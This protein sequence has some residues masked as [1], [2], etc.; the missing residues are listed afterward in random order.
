MDGWPLRNEG[1]REGEGERGK[2]KVKMDEK[3]VPIDVVVWTTDERVRVYMP[4]CTRPYACAHLA[5]RFHP[6]FSSRLL[7]RS[8][9]SFLCCPEYVRVPTSMI[10]HIVLYIQHKLAIILGG[11]G[12]G[13]SRQNGR[14]DR[15]TDGRAIYVISLLIFRLLSVSMMNEQ[16]LHSFLLSRF[17]D[18]LL[19]S[20]PCR[21]DD[22]AFELETARPSTFDIMRK[23]YREREQC[24]Y[25]RSWSTMM[26]YILRQT[27]RDLGL[28]IHMSGKVEKGEHVCLIQSNSFQLSATTSIDWWLSRFIDRLISE[29]NMGN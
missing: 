5:S 12:D 26:I 27:R 17:N 23:Q 6:C 11:G 7:A 3:S 2:S 14:I 21:K 8:F 13:V 1:E 22:F 20:S 19:F 10:N 25:F 24:P 18:V 9:L 16:L 4:A 15:Q 29:R 28:C